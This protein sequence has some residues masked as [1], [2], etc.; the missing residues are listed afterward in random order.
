MGFVTNRNLMSPVTQAG[1][2]ERG[3]IHGFNAIALRKQ[4]TTP[5]PSLWNSFQKNIIQPTMNPVGW[6]WQNAGKSVGSLGGAWAEHM[7]Q[8]AMSSPGSGG[9]LSG[10]GS[11]LSAA[12]GQYKQQ[13]FMGYL[14]MIMDMLFN[15]KQF[16]QQATLGT[17]Q[18]KIKDNSQ[19]WNPMGWV[20]QQAFNNRS[21]A[22]GAPKGFFTGNRT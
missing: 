11:A 20:Y 22:Y 7:R 2:I 1:R 18:N 15:R 21:N 12:S 6:A 5:I 10:I 16:S 13:G 4:A 19:W 8:N 3:A 17:L 14:Q 9:G